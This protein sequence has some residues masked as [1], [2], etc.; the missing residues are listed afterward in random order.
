MKLH[1]KHGGASSSTTD[2]AQWKEDKEKKRILKIIIHAQAKEQAVHEQTLYVYVY[3]YAICCKTLDRRER[4]AKEDPGK[5]KMENGKTR[6]F[7]S[8]GVATAT[9]KG[10]RKVLF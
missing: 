9:R 5:T 1:D 10:I 7:T 4:N 3:V 6:G 2:C 8:S